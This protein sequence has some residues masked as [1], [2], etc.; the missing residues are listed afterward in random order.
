[1]GARLVE[2]GRVE[3]TAGVGT[4]AV[5]KAAYAGGEG[6]LARSVPWRGALIARLFSVNFFL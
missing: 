2:G 6:K 4:M 5:A 3:S 1:M